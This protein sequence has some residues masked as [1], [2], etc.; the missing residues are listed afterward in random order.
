VFFNVA[1]ATFTPSAAVCEAGGA[2]RLYAV[3]PLTGSPT[4]D[5]AGTSGGGLGDGSGS[6]SGSGGTL[7]GGDRFVLVGQSIPTS[8]KVTFGDD[9]TKAYFGVT[10]GGGIALQPLSLP[11]MQNNVVPVSWRE[12]W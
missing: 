12:V 4:F 2:A 7:S 11:Q 8:L 6:G 1:F 10:K 3:N 9:E 5:L